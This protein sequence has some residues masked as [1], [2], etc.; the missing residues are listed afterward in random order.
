MITF[1]K[2]AKNFQSNTLA[3][4]KWSATRTFGLE[5]HRNQAFRDLQQQLKPQ[6]KQGIKDAGWSPAKMS[7][8]HEQYVNAYFTHD[9][10]RILLNQDNQTI[11][12]I[13]SGLP[14]EDVLKNT[15]L[16]KYDEQA[17]A[18][19][20]NSWL[21]LDSGVKISL[22]TKKEAEQE[23]MSALLADQVIAAISSMNVPQIIAGALTEK[24]KQERLEAQAKH[25]LF[26]QVKGGAA[27][28]KMRQEYTEEQQAEDMQND[29]EAVRVVFDGISGFKPSSQ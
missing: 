7:M 6:I 5:I 2:M 13:F 12:P 28:E 15:V 4:G 22:L 27:L 19:F 25:S 16:P 1:K 20:Q 17:I 14:V 24:L 26:K 29:P 18:E 23:L 3:F 11:E 9:L 10:M 8:D 21:T